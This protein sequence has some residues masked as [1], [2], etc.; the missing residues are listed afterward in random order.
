LKTRNRQRLELKNQWRKKQ[1]QAPQPF[2]PEKRITP[3]EDKQ[4][5]PL[6]NKLLAAT[7]AEERREAGKPVLALGLPALPAVREQ[8][9]LLGPDHPAR[10][11][12]QELARR[13]AL[14]VD[15]V[16][17]AEQ[18]AP[19]SKEFRQQVEQWQGKPL[20]AEGVVDLLLTTAKVL[21]RGARGIRLDIEREGNDTGV[22]LMVTLAVKKVRQTGSQKGWDISHDVTIDGKTLGNSS[23]FASWDYGLTRGCWQSL[24]GSLDKALGA[25]PENYIS[26][27]ARIV[28]GE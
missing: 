19:P 7:T 28:Q 23:G 2:P 18:S 14:I 1:G 22:T 16:R 25:G 17:F 13:L 24:A 4:V 11:D 20:T 15:E 12:L 5:R 6:L 26:V 3:A 21:P 9:A 10:A 8:L 27:R